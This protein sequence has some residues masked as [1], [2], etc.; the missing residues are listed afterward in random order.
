MYSRLIASR[1]NHALIRMR[2]VGPTFA[3][4][5]IVATLSPSG[6]HAQ[7]SY[8]RSHPDTA[9]VLVA[10]LQGAYGE[11]DSTVLKSKGLPYA[12]P[13]A[14]SLVTSSNTC[15]SGVNAYNKARGSGGAALSNAYVVTLG[16]NGFVVINPQERMGEFT[17]MWVFDRHW[18][19]KQRLAH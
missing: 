12:K 7:T 6:A 13:T 18:V 14:I 16:S 9:G 15:K 4:S 10:G 5:M 3:V 17:A 8:C 11:M 19:Y 1:V 2:V